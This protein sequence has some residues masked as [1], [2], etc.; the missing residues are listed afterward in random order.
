MVKTLIGKILCIASI[1]LH[2]AALN[3]SQPRLIE[4]NTLKVRWGP[5]PLVT[6]GDSFVRQP[7]TIRQALQEQYE[8]LPIA[9]KNRCVGKIIHLVAELDPQ[10]QSWLSLSLGRYTVGYR[11]WKPN[12]T[13]VILIYDKK[14]TISGIQRAVSFDRNNLRMFSHDRP[15]SFL[16]QAS[17]MS[18]THS[19]LKRCSIKRRSM[20]SICIRSRVT[21]FILVNIR[22]RLW[23]VCSFLIEIL[24]TICISG[25]TLSNL[26]HQGTGTGLFIQN[27]SSPLRDVI[28]IPQWETDLAQ[29]KWNH[30]GCF[31][32]MGKLRFLPFICSDRTLS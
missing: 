28:K 3:S 21:S 14:G 29:T 7:R 6:S 25:R 18:I 10:S 2:S 20:V 22:C 19:I 15:Y 32:T 26:E 24:G 11:Y 17:L 31:P 30:G 1:V 23:F 27:G 12:D 9:H 8:K 5:D 16:D 4:W 13:A